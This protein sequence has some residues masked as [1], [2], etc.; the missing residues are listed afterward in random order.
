LIA[1]IEDET[2]GDPMN[3]K[4]WVR[5]S[6]DRLGEL[7]ARRGHAADAKT[8]RR[9]LLRL[10]FSLKANRKRMTGPPHRDRD[11]QLRYIARQKERFLRQGWPVISVDTKKKELIG[12]FKNA[13]RTWCRKA[14]EVNAHDFRHDASARASPYG[15]YLVN[16]DRGFG[17]VGTSADTPH[18]AVDAITRWWQ[19]EGRGQFPGAGK[20]LIL[21]D[22][23]GSNGCRPRLWK[24]KLQEQLADAHDLEVTVCHYPR[25]ASKWNPVEHRLFSFISI[26]WAG[27]PLRTLEVMLGYIRDT[28]TRNGLRVTAELTPK[29]YVKGV[30]VSDRQMKELR[31]RRHQTCP[32]WNYT[33]KPRRRCQ[34]K[35]ESAE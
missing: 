25:G 34:A 28:T 23:G 32:S 22:A 9:L 19:T 1:L 7:L 18:F 17:Y 10:G 16:H 13:G 4:E 12:N 35:N 2:G 14:D 15:I 27:R 5:P 3:Q 21:A 8:V 24:L 31:L 33:I 6:L 29:P 20:M 26:N 11:R 30:K